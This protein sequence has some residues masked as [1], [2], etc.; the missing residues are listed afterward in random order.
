MHLLLRRVEQISALSLPAS[1]SMRNSAR[2]PFLR[3]L[4]PPSA[5]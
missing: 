2:I 3:G 1:A 4:R 5:A